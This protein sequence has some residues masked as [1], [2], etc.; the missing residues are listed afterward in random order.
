MR[1]VGLVLIP[2][3]AASVSAAPSDAKIAGIDLGKIFDPPSWWWLPDLLKPKLTAKAY[4]KAVTIEG[5][6]QHSRALSRFA[7]IDGKNTRSFGTPGYNASV[8]YVEKW[9]KAYGYDVTRQTVLYPATEHLSQ[10]LTVGDKVFSP[11]DL[12]IF[13]F[14]PSTPDGGAK[15]LIYHVNQG[16]N[17]SDFEGTQG[18]IV[19]ARRGNCT[20]VEKGELAKATGVQGLIIYNDVPGQPLASRLNISSIEQNPPTLAISFEAGREIIAKLEAGQELQTTL[21]IQVKNLVRPADNVIA[22]TKWGDKNNVVMLG[23]HLDSV[24][25]G[26]GIND[27]GSGTAGVAELLKQLAR[28]RKSKNAVRFAWWATEEVG[29]IGSRYYVEQLSQAE[30]DKIALYINLDMIASPNYI[31]GIHDADNSGGQNSGVPAP[32]GSNTLEAL[33]QDYYNDRG[34]NWT[35]TAFTAGSDYRPFLDAG[36]VA[37]GIA[38]GASGVKNQRE[39][40][41]F[42]GELGE[43]HDKCY[44]QPCDTLDNLNHDAFI[45]ISRSVAYLIATLSADVSPIK[46]E[47]GLA[48]RGLPLSRRAPDEVSSLGKNCADHP[49]L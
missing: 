22:Q 6:L 27:D 1:S 43:W 7:A 46:N 47:A 20:F 30:K 21:D 14:V 12:R 5:L 44:H 11:A 19:L 23:G 38:T 13:Q 36:I 32:A 35:G 42:G 39:F 4:E 49:E 28:F 16:C 40:D 48:A 15:G 41:L 31:I 9:A 45:R 25:A 10:A 2:A 17:P 37:G 34:L 3:L 18:G 29:L 8:E 26:P 33:T 24:P